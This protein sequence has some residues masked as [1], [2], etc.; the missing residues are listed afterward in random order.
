MKVEINQVSKVCYIF[1]LKLNVETLD[2]FSLKKSIQ[3]LW[4]FIT[5][6][7]VNLIVFHLSFLLLN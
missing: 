3:N 7:P 2:Y 4:V 5:P 1:N 6:L